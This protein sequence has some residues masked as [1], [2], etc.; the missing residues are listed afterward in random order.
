LKGLDPKRRIEIVPYAVAAAESFAAERG[1]PFR[2]GSAS[3]LDGGLDGKVGVSNNLTVDFT[4]NPDFGQVE[5]DPSEVNLTAFETFF[6][7]KRP[8]FVEGKDI[9]D[10]RLAPA[11]T[12]GSFTGDRLFYSRRIGRPPSLHPDVP[13]GAFV[14]RPEN[15]TILGAFKLSGK[16]ARGLSIGVLESVTAEEEAL[17]D[18][19][20]ERGRRTVEPLTS[21]FV[22]RLRQD[23]RGGE[24]QVGGMLTAVHRQLDDEGLDVLRRE[25]YAGGFDLSH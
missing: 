11:V 2:D 23:F 20:G 13:D 15:T 10:L 6:D 3:N 18:D 9:F 25:A 22:G 4:L 7:E 16:T 17:I 8:F 21:Y 24:T 14:G 19:G 1:N 12:G 5:A